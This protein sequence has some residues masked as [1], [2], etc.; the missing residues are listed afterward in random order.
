MSAWRRNVDTRLTFSP[1]RRGGFEH[2]ARTVRADLQH[3]APPISHPAPEHRRH[4]PTR[5]RR[6]KLK[7]PP[8][9]KNGQHTWQLVKPR[10]RT[11]RASDRYL[12]ALAAIVSEDRTDL[13][14]FE[15]MAER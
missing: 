13:P 14:L 6:A 4:A 7:L 15:L 12:R 11:A 1:P 2:Q 10:L 5:N 9:G 3:S 8:L